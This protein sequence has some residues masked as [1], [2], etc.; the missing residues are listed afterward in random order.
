[1]ATSTTITGDVRVILSPSAVDELLRGKS[2]PVVRDLFVR[3]ERVKLRAISLAP[4]K[5]GNLRNHIV[6]RL[7]QGPSGP[8]MQV[9]VEGV[10][11]AL[12]VH[13]GARPH[14]IV[15]RNAPLLVF[16]WPK[17]GRVMYLKSVNHPGN[18]P[19]RFLVQSLSAAA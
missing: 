12:Y 9:G 4:R 17:A 10:P 11:Y 3:G 15:A 6:K 18:R 13:E 16:F 8:E 14:R 5:T 2:G 1:M 19:H 7:V